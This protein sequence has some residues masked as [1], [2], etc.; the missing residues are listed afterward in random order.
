MAGDYNFHI[1]QHGQDKTNYDPYHK[2]YTSPLAEHITQCIEGHDFTMQNNR[3][4]KYN[5]TRDIGGFQTQLD[6][7]CTRNLDASPAKI[8]RILNSIS[9]HNMVYIDV[10]LG[11]SAKR[12]FNTERQNTIEVLDIDRLRLSRRVQDA[13]WRAIEDSSI[14]TEVKQILRTRGIDACVKHLEKEIYN[15]AK[16]VIGTKRISK[17]SKRWWTAECTATKDA[18]ETSP[19]CSL[20]LFYNTALTFFSRGFPRQGAAILAVLTYFFMH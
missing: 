9:D 19:H 6:Y 2:G 18:L 13:Y 8:C 20:P 15:I 10:N 14:H 4:K 3:I 1:G 5:F 11:H 17:Y 16:N 7:I 12:T